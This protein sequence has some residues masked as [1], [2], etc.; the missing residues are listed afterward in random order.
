LWSEPGESAL[1]ECDFDAAAV[2]LRGYRVEV[3]ANQP[4][5]SLSAV[6]VYS[7]AVF[8]LDAAVVGIT[9]T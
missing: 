9:L 3:D 5:L 2:I 6:S 7:T 4:E 1:G 8:D